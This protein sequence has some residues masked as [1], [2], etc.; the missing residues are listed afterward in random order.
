MIRAT[1][2]GGLLTAAATDPARRTISGVAVPYGVEGTVSSGDVVVFEPGSLDAAARPVALRDH[3]RTRPIGVVTAAANTP[4]A[5][6][7]TVRISGTRDGDDALVLAADGALPMFSVGA[8]PT[9]YSYDGAGVLRVRAARWLELSL[10]TIG[11]YDTARVASVTATQ[12]EGDPM[13]AVLSDEP[14]TPDPDAPP[15]DDDDLEPVDPDA[16][17]DD[18][19]PALVPDLIV[20]AGARPVPLAAA[21]GRA[22]RATARHPYA[23]VG[24]AEMARIL[25]ASRVD[26]RAR[27]VLGQITASAGARVGAIEA[28]LA[29]ITLVGTDNIGSAMRPGYQAELVDIVSHGSPAVD[30]VRQGDLQRGDYPNVTFNTWTKTPQVALQSGEKVAINS[31]AVAIGPASVPVKTWAT[32]NDI[33]QQTLDFGSPSFV[34]DYIR[35]AGVDYAEVIDTYAVTA[36]LAAATDVPSVAGSDL[37]TIIGGLFAGLDPTKVPAGSMSML[38]AWDI[39]V[40]AMGVKQVDAPAFW[41]GQISLGAFVPSATMGGLSIAVDPNMPAATAI[42]MLRNAATWYDLPGTPFTLRAIN[43]GQLGLDVAVYGYGAL[44]VQYPGAIVKT[45]VP[46]GP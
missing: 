28:A 11:A 32:G 22:G 34:E 19:E 36:L 25:A 12:P 42:L 18:V 20:A 43:V 9:D 6:T 13:P 24:I 39:G 3:D 16:A 46:A 44:G 35:A 26:D 7:A 10:L 37:P 33:S 4:G 27:R 31:T 40:G 1:F 38:V 5:L 21:R 15:D 45:T 23:G 29:D 17:T 41:D 8:D 2:P 14:V 30:M